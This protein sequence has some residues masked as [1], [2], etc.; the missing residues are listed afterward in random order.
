MNTYLKLQPSTCLQWKG[1]NKKEIQE[2][3]GGFIKERE[4][5]TLGCD[6]FPLHVKKGDWV[7]LDQSTNK[8]STMKDEDFKKHYKTVADA[9]S[10][11]NAMFLRERPE[12]QEMFATVEEFFEMDKDI[13]F[14]KRMLDYLSSLNTMQL[15]GVAEQ[16]PDDELAAEAKKL[17][18]KRTGEHWFYCAECDYALVTS[19]M[20]CL[21]RNSEED[22]SDIEF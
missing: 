17:L 21:N 4:D 9:S 6:L 8:V 13:F 7:I 2:H 5:G 1:N 12:A 19:D 11:L 15:A 16:N 3:I 14:K 10:M 18:E 20:C 22:L